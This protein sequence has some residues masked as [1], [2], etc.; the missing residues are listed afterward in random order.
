MKL[1]EFHAL[2]G[3]SVRAQLDWDR[4]EAAGA[5]V[6][7]EAL[8]SRAA[9][10]HLLTV[11]AA[12][13]GGAE[14]NIREAGAVPLTVAQASAAV[15]AWPVRRARIEQFE[16]HMTAGVRGTEPLL[17]TLPAYAVGGRWVILDSTHRAVAAYIT[18]LGVSVVVLTITGPLDNGVLPYM[19]KLVAAGRS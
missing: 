3:P 6:A 9:L 2:F 17:L 13:P 12:G 8:T 11:W 18:A 14:R 5:S 19:D 7:V 4:L 15:T 16:Q 1:A 10:G